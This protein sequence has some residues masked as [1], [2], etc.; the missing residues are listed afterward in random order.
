MLTMRGGTALILLGI[1]AILVYS[2][3]RQ[4]M[5]V[6]NAPVAVTASSPAAAKPLPFGDLASH[7]PAPATTPNSSSATSAKADLLDKSSRPDTK[8]KTEVALTAAAIAASIVQESRAQYHAGGRPCACPDDTMRN[9]HACGG[10]SAYSRPG[11]ASPL[12]YASD[13]TAAMIES[14]RQKQASR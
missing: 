13:V 10:R 12:C 11:G 2:M 7:T 14:Y 6:N 8:R 9:G 3:G 1:T 4:S 5:P